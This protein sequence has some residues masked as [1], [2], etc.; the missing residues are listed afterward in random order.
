MKIAIAGGGTGGHIYPAVAVVNSLV[1]SGKQVDVSFVG[2]RRGLEGSI[3]PALGYRMRHIMSRPLPT[4]PSVGSAL[5]LVCAFVGFVQSLIILMTDR[6]AVVIGTGGYASGPFVTAARLFGVPILLIEPN[7]VPGRTTMLLARFVDEVALG[8]QESVRYFSKGTNLRVTGVPTRP[9]LLGNTREH[10]ISMFNLEPARKTVFVFGG[11]RG[12]S[13]IN[14]AFVEAA[15][16]LEGRDDLQFV[17][18]TGKTD[19]EYVSQAVQKINSLCRVYPYIDDI[20]SAYAASDLVVCRAGAG[21]VAEVTACG[22]PSILIPYPYAAGGHQEANAKLLERIGAASVIR[23]EDLSGE[24]L[25]QAI[26]SI[27]Y[28]TDK[29]TKMSGRSR[30]L[31]RPDAA[32]DISLRVLELALRKGRLSKLATVLAELCS[33]K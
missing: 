32:R 22:L 28:D 31:G 25:A 27:I 5:S 26:V 3:V 15:T 4:G 13:S 23:D 7:S 14:K 18:Q 17:A 29:M 1:K 2:T 21:S 9:T 11:S 16:A 10:G 24:R 8:F 12:A 20:G 30:E 6:P 33:V 19:Y